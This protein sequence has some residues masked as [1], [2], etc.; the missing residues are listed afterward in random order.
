M[1]MGI[2]LGDQVTAYGMTGRAVWLWNNSEDTVVGIRFG[3]TL[4]IVSVEEAE[5]VAPCNTCK[6]QLGGE[7]HLHH[8]GVHKDFGC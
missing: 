3:K 7:C 5:R 8:V 2:K 6:Y 1:T 4:R